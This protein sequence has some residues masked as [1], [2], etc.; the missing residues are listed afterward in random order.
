MGGL[1]PE[2]LRL[3]ATNEGIYTQETIPDLGLLKK[4]SQHLIYFTAYPRQAHYLFY[5]VTCLY[6][7]VGNHN[8]V[9]AGGV[10]SGVLRSS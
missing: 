2:W 6:R 5:Y 7:V 9:A 1:R 3:W 4:K 8:A 10:C